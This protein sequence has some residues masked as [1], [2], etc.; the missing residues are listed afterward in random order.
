MRISKCHLLSFSPCG[1]TERVLD[2]L[3]AKFP[4]P[5]E[6]HNL[7]RPGPAIQC[8]DDE[9]AV[10]AFPVYMGRLPKI[11]EAVMTLLKGDGSPAVLVAVYG[12]RAYSEAVLELDQ[13]AKDRGFIPLAAVTAIAEHSM[14]PSVAAGRPD[15]ADREVLAAFGEKL[16]KHLQ[17]I[18]MDFRRTF[19]PPGDK[20]ETKILPPDLFAPSTR[21]EACTRCGICVDV[22]PTGAIPREAPNTTHIQQCLWCQACIKYCPESARHLAH[23]LVP[24]AKAGLEQRCTARLEAELWM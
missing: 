3:K 13:L 7:T 24:Q 11:A 21:D 14:V 1:G 10:I 6:F 17:G 23:A 2:A 8:K 18:N 20:I 5:A 22:C 4:W 12:N 9:L 15:Q 19:R 16:V